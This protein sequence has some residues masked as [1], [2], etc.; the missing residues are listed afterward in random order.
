M[1]RE[2]TDLQ[3]ARKLRKGDSFT[4]HIATLEINQYNGHESLEA[5]ALNLF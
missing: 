2:V 1:S 3:Y 4:N 5:Q